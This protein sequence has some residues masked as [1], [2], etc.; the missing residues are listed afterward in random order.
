MTGVMNTAGR[1]Y[2]KRQRRT[3]TAGREQIGKF[4]YTRP[5]TIAVFFHHL[6]SRMFILSYIYRPSCETV[7]CVISFTGVCR[8]YGQKQKL[9]T[10]NLS[11]LERSCKPGIN[12]YSVL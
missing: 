3:R 1:M 8:G 10:K 7:I 2:R 11:K 6:K 4:L 9:C 12:N 5:S